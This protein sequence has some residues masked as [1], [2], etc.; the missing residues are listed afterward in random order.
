MVKGGEFA[1]LF[2]NAA[3]LYYMNMSWWNRHRITFQKWWEVIDDEYTPLWDKDE[4]EQID[5]ETHDQGSSSTRTADTTTGESDQKNSGIGHDQ[6]KDETKSQTKTY[7]ADH[8]TAD[9][10][11]GE[12]ENGVSAYD[13]SGYSPHDKSE[14][15]DAHTM[16]ANGFINSATQ[17][18]VVHNGAHSTGDA[19]IGHTS[20]ENKGT[21]DTAHESEGSRQ[22]ALHHWGNA[23]IS[24][25]SQKLMEQ[26]FRIRAFD[27]Y[28]HMADIFI[29]ELCVR[30]YL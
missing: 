11:K 13:A 26:E 14:T 6:Y 19:M 24:T 21:S 23:G 18:E 16:N 3:T 27:I 10:S 22:H 30:V 2:A 4:Y 20:S 17:G 9:Q 25:T 12:I 29:D 1:P 5:E 7:T 15:R 8:V 28:D